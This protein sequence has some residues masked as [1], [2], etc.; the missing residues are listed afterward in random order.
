AL[1]ATGLFGGPD[2]AGRIALSASFRPF[3][4]YLSRQAARVRTALRLLGSSQRLAV[5]VEIRAAALF[6]AGLYFECH[7]YLEDI[8]RASAGPERSFY[9]GLVQA[10]AGLYHFEKG[11]AHGT[12]S[13]LG[14]A[15][16]KLEPYAPAYREVD[17]AALLIGL[18]GGL[19]RLNG[20]PA[21]L[22]PD[23]AGKPSVFL[24]SVGTPPSTRRE[25]ARM[26]RVFQYIDAHRAEYVELLRG[27]CRRPSIAAQGIGL[28]ETAGQVEALMDEAGIH[29]R[30]IA[31]EGGAPVVYGEVKGESPRALLFY[32]HYD[33]QP[34]EPLEEW[35]SDPFGAVIRDDRI[36]ARGVADNK[37]NLV[38]RICAVDA[39]LHTLGETPAT[40][41]FIVEGEEEIGSVH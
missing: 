34:P 23:S 38:A 33:V 19:N 3:A 28:N 24:E 40:A 5:P 16:A 17:V 41:R 1:S 10:A 27:L 30:T 35:E 15:I 6:N 22:R 25:G 13:L 26:D 39:M 11:N 18:R 9:H 7:E 36:Y 29:A 12:R 32:N 31:V 8:W 2:G 14:K 4:P 37:G 20:A 21:A